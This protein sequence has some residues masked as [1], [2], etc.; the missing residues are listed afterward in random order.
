M[1]TYTYSRMLKTTPPTSQSSSRNHKD[2]IPSFLCS[3]LA[4]YLSS[5]L[6]SSNP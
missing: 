2:P 3:L 5:V 4:H 1:Y 6:K